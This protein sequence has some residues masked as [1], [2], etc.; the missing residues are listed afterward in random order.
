MTVPMLAL[1]WGLALSSPANLR[2]SAAVTTRPPECSDLRGAASP[3]SSARATALSAYCAALAS[4]SSKLSSAPEAALA[5]ARSADDLLAE[6]AATAVIS[7]RALL[8]L[9]RIDESLAEFDRALARDPRALEAPTALRDHATALRR[10]GRL[11]ASLATYRKLVPLAALLPE[12]RD[13]ARTLLETAHVAMA[14]ERGRSA[15]ELADATN[16][17]QGARRLAA[18]SARV[19]VTLSLVLVLERRGLRQE[20][21]ALLAE[22]RGVNGWPEWSSAEYLADR[23]DRLALAALALE[24]TDPTRAVALYGKYLADPSVTGRWRESASARAARLGAH[25]TSRGTP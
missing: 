7:A 16:Y 18:G 9:G 10:A 19:E 5:A 23:S 13:A 14:L 21:D 20:A 3:W 11:D 24:R 4:A 12:A 17:L 8:R 6:R 2:S 25:S 15:P 1:A 22:L